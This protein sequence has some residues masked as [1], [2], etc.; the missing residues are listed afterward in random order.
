MSYSLGLCKF[1][2]GELVPPDM[3]VVEAVLAPYGAVPG[4]ATADGMEFWIRA[5]DGGEA[6]LCVSGDMVGVERPA[7]GE[8]RGVIAELADRIGAGVL[9]PRGTFL[10]RED[11]RSHLPEGMENDSVFVSEIT[12]EALEDVEARTAN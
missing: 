7:L 5:D 8:I 6:E 9:T 1:V 3:D 12:R 11:S 2:D 10:F 4:K